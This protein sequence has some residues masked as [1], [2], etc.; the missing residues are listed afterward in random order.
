MINKTPRAFEVR[1]EQTRQEAWTPKAKGGTLGLDTTE[2]AFKWCN[3][4]VQLDTTLCD[5]MWLDRQDQGWTPVVPTDFPEFQGRL[6]HLVKNGM[7]RRSGQVLCKM[8]R[9]LAESRNEYYRNQDRIARGTAI[10]NGVQAVPGTSV[11]SEQSSANAVLG[12][13]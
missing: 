5:R 11:N 6:K 9:R 3:T 7:V 10:S 13:R 4:D 12:T 2:W 8:E 1:E